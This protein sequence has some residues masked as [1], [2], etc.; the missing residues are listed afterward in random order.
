MK[1]KATLNLTNPI[2]L[3]PS[4][5]LYSLQSI[6]RT[7]NSNMSGMEGKRLPSRLLEVKIK[8]ASGY[9]NFDG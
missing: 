5:F 6:I 3:L 9:S 7:S 4:L 1:L 2:M 8:I